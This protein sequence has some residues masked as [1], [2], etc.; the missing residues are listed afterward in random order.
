MTHSN[1]TAYDTFERFE[2]F[3]SEKKYR[4]LKLQECDKHYL[5]LKL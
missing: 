4:D 3:D 5:F 2:D 1:L